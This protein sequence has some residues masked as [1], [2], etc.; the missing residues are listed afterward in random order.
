MYAMYGMVNYKT[1]KCYYFQKDNYCKN[2]KACQFAHSDAEL[3]TPIEMEYLTSL[4]SSLNYQVSNSGNY[5]NNQQ[6]YDQQNF[7][8]MGY[9]INIPVY[10]NYDFQTAYDYSYT[11]DTNYG[12]GTNL[13]T[14]QQANYQNNYHQIYDYNYA[15][16][17]PNYDQNNINY[18]YSDSTNTNNTNPQISPQQPQTKISNNIIKEKVTETTSETID[19]SKKKMKIDF[20]KNI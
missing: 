14:N 19:T 17:L 6:V 8:N 20:S 16:Y 3:R 13:E 18:N 12:D 2:G 9:D 5:N 1:M 11:P 7:Y 10:P 4:A 15:N